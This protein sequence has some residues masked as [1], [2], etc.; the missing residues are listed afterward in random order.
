MSPAHNMKCPRIACSTCGRLIG[1]TA[2]S[3]HEKACKDPNSWLSKNPHA[4]KYKETPSPALSGEELRLL[5]AENCERMRK[6]ITPESIQK[7]SASI[8]QAHAQG[9]YQS[10]Y[11]ANKGRNKPP[12]PEETR[13]KLSERAKA[14]GH[15]RL[16]RRTQEYCGVLF[17]SSWEVELAKWLNVNS[18]A[19]LRPEPLRYDDNR[20]Y[21]PDFYLPEFTLY[22]DTKNDYLIKNDSAKVHKAAEQNKVEILILSE[23]DLKHLGVL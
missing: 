9:K 10:L 7:R 11:E 12:M 6:K 20:C 3:R 8:K 4:Y 23:R 19:W 22:V 14:S 21:F 5:R 18:I 15:R 17:D 2:L 1:K 13:K 16:M